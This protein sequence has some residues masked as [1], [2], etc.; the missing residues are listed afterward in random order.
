M[1]RALRVLLQP[2]GQVLALALFGSLATLVAEN[3]ASF[4]VIPA[5]LGRRSLAGPDPPEHR[6]ESHAYLRRP[7]HVGEGTSQ[8]ATDE[9]SCAWGRLDLVRENGCSPP[10]STP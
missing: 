4:G 6:A 10:R 1:N 2:F 5:A 7:A 8:R 3:G 9:L